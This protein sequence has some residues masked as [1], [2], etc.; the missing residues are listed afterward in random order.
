M[1]IFE[2]SPS[3]AS[4]TKAKDCGSKD[5]CTSIKYVKPVQKQISFGFNDDDNNYDV[6][7][8]GHFGFECSGGIAMQV[9]FGYRELLSYTNRWKA[10]KEDFDSE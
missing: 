9:S 8:V 4:R 3:G 10:L 1:C 6:M 7:M 5:C 2:N